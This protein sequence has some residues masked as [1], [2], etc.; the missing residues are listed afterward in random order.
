MVGGSRSGTAE[1]IALAAIVRSSA[2]AVIA[3]AVDGT[4]TAWNDGASVIYGYS[5]ERMIG[6]NIELTIPPEALD[7]ERARHF[8]AASGVAEVGY[9]C[10]RLRADGSPIEVVMSMSPV[11]DDTGRVIGVASISRPVSDR[12]STDARF[13]SLLEAAPDAMVC[14]DRTGLIVLVNAQVATLFGYSRHEL[15]GM[16]VEALVP[17]ESRPL[18]A[19]HRA[20]FFLHP[21]PRAMGADLHL[22]GRRRDGSTFPVEVSLAADFSDSGTLAIAAVRDVS[23]QRA[24]EASLRESEARLRQLAEHVDTV[25]TLVQIDPF[26]YLYV[27]PSFHTLTGLEPADLEAHPELG[28]ACIHPDDRDHVIND[29]LALPSLGLVAKSEHRVVRSNGEV[30]WVRSV[31]SPVLNPDGLPARLVTTTEDVTDRVLAAIALGEA[32]AA[33]RSA[34]EAKNSFLSRMSHEL[35]TP[36]NA[37]LGFGQLLEH[38]LEHTEHVES[39]RHIVRAGRHLLNL[40]NEVL[41]I[42]R[43]EAGELS[44]SPEPVALGP[45]IEESLLLMGPMADGVGVTLVNEDGGADQ[46][47]LAD[48]QRLRQV[49]LNLISNAVKYNRTTGSVWVSWTLEQQGV[50]ILVRDNGPGIPEELHDRLFTAFDRLGAETTGIEGT[51][52]GLAVTLALVEL[53]H[54][55]LIFESAVGVGTTFTVTLPPSAPPAMSPPEVASTAAEDE[56][57]VVPGSLTVLYIED[58][59]PNVHVMESVLKLRPGWRLIHAGL[60]RLGLELARAHHPALVLLDVHLPDG[61]GLD[62]LTAMKE[63]PQTAQ[64]P[65]VV[66]SADANQS[67]IKRLLAAGAEQYLTKPLDLKE[68][69]ALFDAVAHPDEVP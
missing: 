54:G 46:H 11:R 4:I 34:N 66:L 53:M 32:E 16:S 58:N 47:V 17:D 49:L 2:D 68:V 37:I 48:R 24:F 41:D 9:R 3:K 65:V 13:A 59:E 1:D 21:H 23:Q 56:A 26:A 5:P 64:I 51:G 38:H 52:M 69:L 30:R 67:Q 62:V 6:Q 7:V 61:S 31:A 28:L 27:S 25:F 55:A 57:V 36:L 39:V 22:E 42:T 10:V 33:A 43:I 15:I 14:V 18:H 20:G 35:R 44:I 29:Y 12:E 63:D 8:R 45:I 40:I 19:Q 60:A 50:S